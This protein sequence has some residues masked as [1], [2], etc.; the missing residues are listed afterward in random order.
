MTE[1]STRTS[2]HTTGVDEVLRAVGVDAETGLTPEEVLARA[3]R[4]G[5]NEIAETGAKSPWRI[6]WE[7]FTATMV[8]I[9]LA[10]A[11]VS[12]VVG[13]LKDTVVILA[14]VVLFAVLGFVQEYRAE[15]AMAA[16]KRLSSPIVRVR[17]GGLIEE[18]PSGELVPGDIV[19]LEAGNLVP[20][21]CRLVDGAIAGPVPE[22]PNSNFRKVCT[23]LS[24]TTTVERGPT[25]GP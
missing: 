16:L 15:R 19:L 1:I 4:Y 14:I 7:Q 2:W 12:A 3:E 8:L 9:L 10:A 17:R 24:L 21:D 13:S 11:G 25:R 5:P 22:N 18:V 20:A 6:L 23:P